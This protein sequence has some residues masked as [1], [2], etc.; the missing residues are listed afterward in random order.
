MKVNCREHSK[1]MELLSLRTRLEKGISDP[2]ERKE[3]RERIRALEEE[4]MLD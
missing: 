4:L 2:E 1:T 3:V